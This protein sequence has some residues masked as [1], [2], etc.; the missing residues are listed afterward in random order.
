MTPGRFLTVVV[1]L[2]GA[3][4]IHS[5]MP[6]PPGQVAKG[7]R[8]KHEAYLFAHI[9]HGDYWR[10]YYSVSLD[11]LHWEMLNGG[12]RVFEEY[13]GHADICKGHDGHYYLVG[14]RGDEAPDINFWVSDDLISWKKHSDYVP[15]LKRVPDYPKARA[16]IGA[17]KLFFDEASSQYLVTFH[18][19][20]TSHEAKTTTTHTLLTICLSAGLMALGK[21]APR[22]VERVAF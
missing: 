8:P 1:A 21:P 20:R 4:T 17:P 2:W 7:E 11:G 12:K 13:R 14:N 19:N 10:L 3:A 18:S 16:R 22:A 9:L 5:Q 6:E 15:D